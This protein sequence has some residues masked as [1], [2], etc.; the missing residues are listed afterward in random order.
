MGSCEYG[1]EPLVCTE[2]EYFLTN[3]VNG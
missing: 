2:D 1:N 3:W